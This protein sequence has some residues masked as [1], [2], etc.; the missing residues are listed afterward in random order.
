MIDANKANKKD[1]RYEQYL[2]QD[3][4]N[5]EITAVCDIFDVYGEDAILAGSN[6]HREGSNGKFGKAPKRYRHYKEL[7]AAED[8]DAVIIGTPDQWLWKR[9]KPANMYTAKNR[10]LGQF[11]KPTWC[12]K[13]LKK[14]V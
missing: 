14:L 12:G 3:D 7:L 8:V 6:I 5:I 1:T 10:Y 13:R 9:Q 2:E 11:L 4:L